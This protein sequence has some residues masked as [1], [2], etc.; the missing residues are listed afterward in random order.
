MNRGE[1]VTVL[2]KDDP[3]WFYIR[4]TDSSE[5][6]V[7]GSFLCPAEGQYEGAF[8]KMESSAKHKN[9]LLS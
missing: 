4:R 2:N 7:P 1:F 9:H 8:T 5:G 6:F 3:D